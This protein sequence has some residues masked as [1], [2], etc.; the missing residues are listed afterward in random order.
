MRHAREST[1]LGA[2]EGNRL[3][4]SDKDWIESSLNHVLRNNYKPFVLGSDEY[5]DAVYKESLSDNQKRFI[6]A[7][8][9]YGCDDLI[10]VASKHR[11]DL[12]THHIQKA[13][14]V[15]TMDVSIDIT[16][17]KQYLDTGTTNILP[18]NASTYAHAVEI[19]CAFASKNYAV[20]DASR[21]L[22]EIVNN[23]SSVGQLHR[24]IPEIYTVLGTKFSTR[25]AMYTR[26]PRL[27]ES[28]YVYETASNRHRELESLKDLLSSGLMLEGMEAAGYAGESGWRTA[29]SVRVEQRK[30]SK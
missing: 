19:A 20:A 28:L 10:N 18:T 7:S 15:L 16:T 23:A 8:R 5:H 30:R 2:G 3:S 11:I 29:F 1:R 6:M 24:L 14:A 9:E 22:W 17:T 21:T 27:N 13:D 4:V 12:G 26:K 25:Q